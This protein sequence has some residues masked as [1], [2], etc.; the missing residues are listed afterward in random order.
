MIDY[1]ISGMSWIKIKK[2]N[3]KHYP[4]NKLSNCQIE[5]WTD[6]NNLIKIPLEEN[7]KIAPLRIL[8][9]DIE[10]SS[11]NSKFPIP[12][13]DPIIV[14]SN[15]LFE[16][17]EK[18]KKIVNQS[19]FSFYKCANISNVNIYSFDNEI[20]LLN[21]WR[22]FII[23]L[24]PDIITGFNINSFDFPYLIKRSEFL[25]IQNFSSFT[26][27]KNSQSYLSNITKIYY[28]F[29]KKETS[30]CKITGRI[31]LD[32]Y[33]YIRIRYNLSSYTLNNISKEFLNEQKE[34]VHYSLIT[35]LWKKDEYTRR[36]LCLYCLKDS[37]LPLKLIQKLM[38]IINLTEYCRIASIPLNFAINNGQQISISSILHKKTFKLNYLIP[39]LPDDKNINNENNINQI[40]N[41]LINNNNSK[42]K[43]YSNFEGASVLEPISGFY[44]N[45][46]VTLDFSSLY[47]SIMIAHNLCYSTLIKKEKLNKLNL[48]EKDY[49]KTP[50]GDYFINNNIR[51]GIIPIILEELISERR[52][53]KNQYNKEKNIDL[54]EILNSRQ[55]SI[56]I[57]CNSFYGFTGAHEGFLPCIQISS[58]ITSI[59]RNMIELTRNLI[60]NKYNINNGY[61]YN[62]N[63]IY[64]DTDS[65]M[66]NFGVNNIK[67]ALILGKESSDFITN[68]FKKPIQIEFEKVFFPYLLLK[69]KRYIGVI[70]TK[71]NNYDKIDTKGI[72]TVRRNNCKLIKIMIENVIQK[73]FIEKNINDAILYCKDIINNLLQNKID[74]SLLI[75]T[76]SFNFSEYQNRQA[77]IEL[78]EKM[79]KRNEK[80]FPVPGERI[81]YL[82]IKGEKNSKNY[83][84]SENPLFA[85]ENDIEIDVDYYL[86]KQIKKPILRIFNPIIKNAEQIL[87]EGEH[88]KKKI[89]IVNR[90]SYFSNF[91]IEKKICFNCKSTINKGVVCK[92]CKD[93]LKQIYI[94]NKIEYN[95]YQKL[96]CDLWTQ[97]QRCQGSIMQDIICQNNDCP[98]FYKRIQ[99]KKNLIRY[100]EKMDRFNE[101]NDW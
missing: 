28:G 21:Q 86:E 89:S 92:N 93:K 43:R 13:K 39:T 77:H 15:I 34:D 54:K 55:N 79:K 53:A 58:S 47:P 18:E 101:G 80:N 35:S 66:I 40:N 41:N 22:N 72:E 85:L 10:C 5:I 68:Q 67:D 97:C 81:P 90:K 56:K 57:L 29:I 82:I 61:K 62:S 84:N 14:I 71:E 59:G 75:I 31:I 11:E 6:I 32:I 94:E 33:S 46:I 98:I 30:E 8:S 3:Y 4:N 36:R 76:K 74:I 17:N 64:G 48:S 78:V 65:V 16:F 45:P 12:E 1:N 23:K 96:Y 42:S 91:L 50:T 99:I 7:N 51:K 9:I 63:I 37:L 19:I 44:N 70:W 87:F 69:K 2:N 49:F 52:K 20:D 38:L 24:D 100:K 73:I 25:K 26:R 60:L 83:E 27:I 88:M 95:N